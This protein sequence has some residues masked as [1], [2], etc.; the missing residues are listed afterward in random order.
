MEETQ[1]A[2]KAQT[3]Q[4]EAAG[5]KWTGEDEEVDVVL[6]G[7]ALHREVTAYMA[8][9]HMSPGQRGEALRTLRTVAFWRTFVG[10]SVDISIIRK[11]VSRRETRGYR[12]TTGQ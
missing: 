7:Q 11:P 1:Q 12:A 6:T 10:A 4:Y 9:Q 3:L 5:D 2:P 8:K